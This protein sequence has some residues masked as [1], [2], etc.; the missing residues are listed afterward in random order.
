MTVIGMSERELTRLRVMIDLADG[1]LT[2]EAA[3][4]L[5][6]IGRRQ[7][8]SL[9]RA[10]EA[11]GPS[12]LASRKRGR[13]SNRKHGETFRRMVL[14]LVRE[15]YPDFGPTFAAE[16]LTERHGLHLG[17]ETLRQWMIADGL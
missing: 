13:R 8:Y 17:V 16:K 10:F 6:G 3:G 1:R 4:T 11:H 2:A 15:H 7:V 14:T 9:C 5:M 12:G